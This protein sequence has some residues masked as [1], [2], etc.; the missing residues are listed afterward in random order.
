[1]DRLAAVVVQGRQ[2]AMAAVGATTGIVAIKP[3]NQHAVEA[4]ESA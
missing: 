3:Q 2:L 1:M 4:V